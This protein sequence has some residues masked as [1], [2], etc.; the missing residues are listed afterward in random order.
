MQELFRKPGNQAVL[1]RTVKKLNRSQLAGAR[2]KTWARGADTVRLRRRPPIRT[3]NKRLE[4]KFTAQRRRPR[5]ERS[6]L[7]QTTKTHTTKTRF[8]T[9]Q[10]RPRPDSYT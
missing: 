10:S 6:E 3:Q 1:S 4:V 2:F 8:T 5:R 7:W 9:S